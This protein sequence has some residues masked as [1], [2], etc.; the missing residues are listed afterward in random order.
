MKKAFTLIELLVVIAII[1][2]LAGMLLPALGKAREAARASHCTSNL[3]NLGNMFVFYADANDGYIIPNTNN[4]WP[5][6]TWIAML[7]HAGYLHIE[8]NPTDL[9]PMKFKEYIFTDRIQLCPSGVVTTADG[10]NG[11]GSYAP[12]GGTTDLIKL[13]RLEKCP[14]AMSGLWPK[15]PSQHLLVYDSERHDSNKQTAWGGSVLDRIA[16]RHN[17]KVNIV[18]ADNHCGSLTKEALRTKDG[19]KWQYG[20]INVGIIDQDEAFKTY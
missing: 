14:D 10:T 12:R 5:Y 2:I 1:A 3:K 17:N 11:Y 15:S 16:L 8:G 7:G 18:F 9:R 13:Y 6:A 19:S 20:G 4:A